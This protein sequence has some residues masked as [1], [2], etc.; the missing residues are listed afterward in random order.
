MTRTRLA[1]LYLL[2]S[3]LTVAAAGCAFLGVAANAIP[4]YTEAR[5]KGLAGQT[6]AVMVWADRGTAHRLADDAAR[7]R[8]GNSIRA[9]A[10]AGR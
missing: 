8:L 7:R 2:S 5:Y 6:I 4:K 1:L 10:A 9:Q 3:M